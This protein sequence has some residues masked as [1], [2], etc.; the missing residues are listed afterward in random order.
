MSDTVSQN[1]NLACDAVVGMMNDD[2]YDQSKRAAIMTI[3]KATLKSDSY[4]N[5]V[6]DQI[7]K[8]NEDGQFDAKDLPSILIIITESKA[9]LAAT[10]QDGVDLKSTLKLDS[11]KYI[12]FGVIYFVML[13]EKVDPIILDE[14]KVVYSSLWDLIAFDPKQLLIKADSCWRKTFPCCFKCACCSSQTLAEK[15]A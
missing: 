2:K 15:W 10:I 13:I 4:I 3:I 5:S 9:F 6:K 8:I 7:K 1:L 14:T 11:M 12:T